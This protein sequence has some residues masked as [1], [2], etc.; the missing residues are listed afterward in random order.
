M[1]R[2]AIIGA[3]LSG[4]TAAFRLSLSGHDIRIFEKSRGFSGRAASRSRN[5]CRYDYGA[6]Y[7]KLNCNAVAQLI[8]QELPTGDLCRIMGEIWTFDRNDHIAPGDPNQNAKAKWAYSGG[9]STLGKLMVEVADLDVQ[10]ECRIERLAHRSGSWILTDERG[11][12][13]GPYETVLVT[14]PAPQAKELLERSDFETENRSR[15]VGE[16][17]RAK[18]HS[19]FS[20]ALNYPGEHRLPGNAYALINSDRSHRV[21]WLS[22]ENQKGG[23]VPDGETLLIAQM[24]PDWTADHYDDDESA[25]HAAADRA[26][27]KLLADSDLPEPGWADSQR[28]RYAHPSSAASLGATRPAASLG[29][30]FAGDAFIGKGRIPRAIETGFAAARAIRSQLGA[31]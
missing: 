8:F 31:A 25:V 13:R 15:L 12:E 27:R 10:R 18:Y 7:F 20:V 17:D 11:A 29:L 23:H 16:L 9:I 14:I 24:S 2:I 3:G 30:Y 1:S 19:Q 28:W 4:L 26:V 21:A 22:H 6:N 5:G